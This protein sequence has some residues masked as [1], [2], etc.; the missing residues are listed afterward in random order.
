MCTYIQHREI[1]LK[2]EQL[3]SRETLAEQEIPDPF[4]WLD[5]LQLG[6]NIAK[7]GNSLSQFPNLYRRRSTLFPLILEGFELQQRQKGSTIAHLR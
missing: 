2:S 1:E 6:I 4:L 5:A 7:E 3:F